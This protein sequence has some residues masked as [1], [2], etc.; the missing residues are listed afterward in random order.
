MTRIGFATGYSPDMNVQKMAAWMQKA[1]ERGYEIGFFS[2]TANVMRDSVSTLAAF[3]IATK[4]MKI[5][6][7]QVVR[8]RSPLL[9]AQT[10]ATL[11]ELSEGRLIL[12]PGACTKNHAIQ[13]SLEPEDPALT[14][15]EYV[16]AL[17]MLVS[18]EKNIRWT[19]ETIKLEGVGLSWTPYRTSIPMWIAATSRTG[20]RIAGEIGDGV[21]LNAVTSPEY[22][23]N[24]VQICKEACE[25][26]GRD[27]GKFEV[28]CLVV[29]SVEDGR[30]EALDAVRW[31]VASKFKRIPSGL[32]GQ[33]IR[34]GDS[35]IHEEDLPKLQEAMKKGGEELLARTLPLSYIENL[36]ASGTPQ[37]VLDRIEKYRGAGVTL[38]IVR[39]AQPHQGESLMAL[40][41]PK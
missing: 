37:E 30:D 4:K 2:E 5:G 10:L 17:R 22:I 28:A 36:T 12:S 38:P 19:G 6:C 40:L 26:A 11:D 21:L 31:E 9:Q 23:R 15:R 13:N 27:W 34:V 29:T 14:L 1:D 24:A 7:T 32:I 35:N 41:A 20:L 16:K 39:P 18:G 33:R 25:A 8:H 3:A